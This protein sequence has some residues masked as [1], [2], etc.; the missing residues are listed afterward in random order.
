VSKEQRRIFK[1]NLQTL[2]EQA[3]KFPVVFQLKLKY[4]NPTLTLM[5]FSFELLQ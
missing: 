5:P 3:E 1:Q 2:Q 4:F